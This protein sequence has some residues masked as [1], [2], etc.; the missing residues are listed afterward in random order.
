[1]RALRFARTPTGAIGLTILVVALLLVVVGPLFAPHSPTRPVGAPGTGPSSDAL[2]GTD[3]L[4]RDVLSRVL[5]GGRSVIALAGIATALAYVAGGITGLVAGYARSRVDGV[6]MR[7]VDVLLAFPPLLVLLVLIAGAGTSLTVLV[8]GVALVQM[9][10]IARLVRSLTLAT[11]GRGYVEAAV[12]RGESTAAILRREIVPSIAGPVMADLGL[13]ITFS[14][15]L[16]AGANFLSLGLQP[17]AS[18]WALMISEN[19][20]FLQLNPWAVAVPAALIAALTI[21]LS[22]T[23]DAIARMLGHSDV[24]ALR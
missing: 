13:R 22:F 18:D 1:M 23:G 8:L 24:K 5:W 16:I 19:R 21:G 7:G 6:L 3:F 14:I 2:L 10:G 12:I 4:G 9:P 17:P 15:L 11:T 20:D